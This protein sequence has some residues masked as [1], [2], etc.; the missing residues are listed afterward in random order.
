MAW[1]QEQNGLPVFSP[2]LTLS[3]WHRA[4]NS[5]S[6]DLIIRQQSQRKEAELIVPLAVNVPGTKA[7]VMGEEKEGHKLFLSISKWVG[8]PITWPSPCHFNNENLK[9]LLMLFNKNK[10]F[11][12]IKMHPNYTW[13]KVK[14]L[15]AHSLSPWTV[16]QKAPLFMVFSQARILEWV[17]IFLLQG[18]FLTQGLN[19]GLLHCKQI[20]YRLSYH[21]SSR[22]PPTKKIKRR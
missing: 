21:G 11:V 15:V 7:W 6:S 18:I 16:A 5:C 4:K 20:L 10:S 17:A 8:V 19:P 9:F 13:L 22:H 12:N 2:G 1:A 3:T 14:V